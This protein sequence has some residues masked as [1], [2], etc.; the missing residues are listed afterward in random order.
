M[1]HSWSSVFCP[2]V[3]S[4]LAPFVKKRLSFLHWL[5]LLLWQKSVEHIPFIFVSILLTL[6]GCFDYYSYTISLNIR[7]SD[8]SHLI[9]LC[10]DCFNILVLIPFNV[11]FRIFLLI[12]TKFD[13]ILKGIA[14]NLYINLG[15]IEILLCWVF[16]SMN[17]SCF[18]NLV[19]FDFFN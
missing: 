4:C 7:S 11:N 1:K 13:G 14:L 12:P 10:K 18:F 8:F 6:M 16:Q 9:L 17:I 15:R 5:L 3:S 19:F 2:W